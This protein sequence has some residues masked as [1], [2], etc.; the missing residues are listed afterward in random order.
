VF[1]E[2]CPMV[3][4]QIIVRQLG[5]VTR[6]PLERHCAGFWLHQANLGR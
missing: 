1:K 3:A 4:A 2:V 6:W 5:R